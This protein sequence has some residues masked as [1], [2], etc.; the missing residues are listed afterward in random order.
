[1]SN[2]EKGNSPKSKEN[3]EK[4]QN[5]PDSDSSQL[6]NFEE[7]IKN[8]DI[9]SSSSD[10]ENN[11]EKEPQKET[12]VKE[13]EKDFKSQDIKLLGNKR[14][15]AK[16]NKDNNKMHNNI[17]YK[18]YNTFDGNKKFQP[19][20]DVPL[21]T[22]E[23]FCEL[24]KEKDFKKNSNLTENDYKILYDEYKINHERKNSEE[25][26]NFHKDDEW[27]LEKYNPY[28]YMQFNYKER[29]EMCQKKAKMFFEF[30]E[31]KKDI[32]NIEENQ[33]NNLT[34]KIKFNYIFD[35]K[36]EYEYNKS[37]KL[38]YTKVDPL[39]NKLQERERDFNNIPYTQ[40]IIQKDLEEDGR[41]YYFYD[42]N[43]LTLYN[44]SGLAKNEQIMPKLNAFK[45]LTGFISLSITE[46]E[47]KNDYKRNLWLMFDSEKNCL[48]ALDDLNDYKSEEYIKSQTIMNP[49]YNKVK[50]TPPLFD[51]R[52]NEDLIGSYKIFN[53][54]DDYRQILENPLKNIFDIN[55]IAIMEKEEKIRI[56]NLNI[57]YLRKVHGF[58][59]YCLKGYKDE[60]NLNKKCDYIHLRHYVQLGKRENM[61]NI[62]INNINITEEELNNAKEFDKYFSQKLNDILNDQEKINE[63]ILL[64]PKYLMEDKF[65]QE[66]LKEKEMGFIKENS[67]NT[68]KEVYQCKICEKKFKA[69]NFIITHI[70][71]KHSNELNEYANN[72]VNKYLMKENFYS[73]KEKFSR[74]NIIESKEYYSSIANCDHNGNSTEFIEFMLKMIDETLE[75]LVDSTS[76]QASHVSSYV[77]KLL[78]VMETGVAMSASELMEKLIIV[79]QIRLMIHIFIKNIKIGMILSISKVIKILIRKLNMMIYE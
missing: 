50:V 7:K 57:L 40:G 73:D 13:K 8:D 53:I 37:F 61:D 69:F 78:S 28:D 52:L 48:K 16:E 62:D 3:Q 77:N 46:P 64:R 79:I 65:A 6:S 2:L 47:R 75:D 59:Y 49:S 20:L 27:F 36:P 33:E 9:I 43:Y 34:K 60:R 45:K 10:E 17:K 70:K 14:S 56:L 26:F 44:L 74:S 42:P 38:L 32:M 29:N 5:E 63:Y 66:K 15:F 11:N 18:T 54:L 68:E 12:K 24:L 58:C 51:E 41:P 30:L 71:N 35:L 1:M 21:V 55:K 22:Y 25:F 67:E 39:N 31:D 19:S 4:N 76:V 23:L 72:K